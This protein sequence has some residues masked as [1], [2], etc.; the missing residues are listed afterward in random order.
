MDFFKKFFWSLVKANI[1]EKRE[2]EERKKEERE[3]RIVEIKKEEEKKEGLEKIA[4]KELM[5]IQP[6]PSKV[7][8]PG[9][10]ERMLESMKEFLPLEKMPPTFKPVLPTQLPPQSL[11]P[12]QPPPLSPT[13]PL[14]KPE[15]KFPFD[16]GKLNIIY[17][18]DIE[19]IQC[20]QDENVVVVYK[21][22]NVETKDIRLSKEE[23]LDL[24]NKIA[25]KVKIPLQDEY[26][27]YLEDFFVQ[28]LMDDKIRIGIKKI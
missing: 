5:P 10:K 25:D 21:N 26:Y 20:I 19:S 6:I 15:Q 18:D 3:E 13:L 23:I 4:A 1:Q 28:I 7:P 2:E 12:L 17:S 24:A 22:G 14:P 16:F 8:R 11:Q 27:V 9:E